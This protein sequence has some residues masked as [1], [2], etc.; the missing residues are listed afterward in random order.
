MSSA[1]ILGNIFIDPKHQDK[2][3]GL[4]IWKLIEQKYPETKIWRTETPGFSKRNHNF[5][6]NKCGFKIVK[7]NSKPLSEGETIRILLN[8][9]TLSDF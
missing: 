6:V 9:M 8:L 5:Y 2:G 3:I 1:S 7:I 4:M